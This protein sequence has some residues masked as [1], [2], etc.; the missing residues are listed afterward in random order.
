MARRLSWALPILFL[1]ISA[2]ATEKTEADPSAGM[3]VAKSDIE[4]VSVRKSQL[5]FRMGYVA[6]QYSGVFDGDFKVYGAFDLDYELFLSSDA[7]VSFRFIQALDNPDSVPFYT[8]AG[9]G[10]KYYWRSKGPLT[11]QKGDGIFIESIPKL[12]FYTGVDLG[13]AQVLTKSFGPN[14]Q[15]VSNMTD[16]GINVGANYQ[17]SRNFGLEAHTGITYGYGFSSTPV[18]GRTQRFLLGGSYYF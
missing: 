17:I 1:S 7:S 13:V 4:K 12:R 5:H 11:I 9:V 3:N 6:G 10:Y 8:Y 16:V 18:N 2:F 14:V 15:S